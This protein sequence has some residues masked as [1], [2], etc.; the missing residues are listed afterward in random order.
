VTPHTAGVTQEGR[1]RIEVMAV[2]RV[3]AFFQGET[4]PN[5]VNPAVLG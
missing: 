4:P 5:V 2:E 3:L 1:E